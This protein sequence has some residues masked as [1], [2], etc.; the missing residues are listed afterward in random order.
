MLAVDTS[1]QRKEPR[2][3]PDGTTILFGLPG[4]RVRHVDRLP[5]LTVSGTTRRGRGRP[6]VVQLDTDDIV[7]ETSARAAVTEVTTD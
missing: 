6:A 5:V 7:D 1:R 4:V 2:V 3:S